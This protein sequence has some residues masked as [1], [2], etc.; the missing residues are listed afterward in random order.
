M[1]LWQFETCYQEWANHQW[2]K[3]GTPLY[4]TRIRMIF[5]NYKI[6]LSLINV[7]PL[8]LFHSNSNH[9]DL[10]EWKLRR[11]SKDHQYKAMH[12]WKS[13]LQYSHTFF[14]ESSEKTVRLVRENISFLLHLSSCRSRV[15]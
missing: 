15:V 7:L 5:Y 2:H 12:L 13:F 9:N 6:C 3:K 1:I 4:N 10:L 14:R 8:I 11:V